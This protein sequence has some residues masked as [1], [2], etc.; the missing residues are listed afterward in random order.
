MSRSMPG[1][2][3]TRGTRAPCH[4]LA[5]VPLKR[6]SEEAMTSGGVQST[7]AVPRAARQTGRSSSRPRARTGLALVLV[8]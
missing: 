8:A 6:C 3:V 5:S 7:R 1:S 4:R 2:V